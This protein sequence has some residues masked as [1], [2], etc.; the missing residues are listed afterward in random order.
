M[1]E[2]ARHSSGTVIVAG[3]TN[4]A[5]A[6]K[7]P[8]RPFAGAAVVIGD[9]ASATQI[10]WHGAV[11]QNDVP[12]QIYSDGSAVTTAVTVGIHPIPDAAFAVNFVVPVLSNGTTCSMTV[13][14]KG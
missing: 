13:M 1:N 12:V 8:M 11:G 4:T 6:D 5:T 9:T 7:I 3:S 14:Q 2:I 10:N